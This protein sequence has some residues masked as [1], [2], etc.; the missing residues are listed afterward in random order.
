MDYSSSAI[1]FLLAA[2]GTC[3]PTRCPEIDYSVSIRRGGNMF[4]EPLPSNGHIRHNTNEGDNT[5][6]IHTS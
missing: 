3:S 1:L 2:T 6:R 4:T 5:V